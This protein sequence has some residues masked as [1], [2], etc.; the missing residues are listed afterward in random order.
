[1]A[2]TDS[3]YMNIALALAER[4]LGRVW[5]NPAVG[6]VLVQPDSDGG[7]GRIVG[8]GWTQPGGRPHAE[9][10]ALAQAGG[11]AKGASAYVSLEPCSHHGKAPPCADAL[12]AAGVSRV[13]MAVEDPDP[14]VCGQGLAKLRAARIEV[15]T[16]LLAREARALNRG[17]FT[18]TALGRPMFTL[19]TATT[20][21]GRIATKSR[22]SKWIT[23]EAARAKGHLLRAQHDAVLT[24]YGTVIADDPLLNC[25]IP[26]LEDRSPIRIVVDGGLQTPLTA[27]VIKTARDI[28]TWII[29]RKGA[30][31]DRRK[32]L[33]KLG[34]DILE[35]DAGADGRPNMTEGARALGE[36][37]LTRVLVEAG[38]ILAASLV[39]SGLA[40]AIAWFRAA[41]L[42]G[43]DGL[44][45]IGDL[46]L[47]GI[48]AAIA[49]EHVS[50]L[51]LG[52]DV[53]ETYV[54]PA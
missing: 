50:S 29:A 40:D 35:V 13:V 48:D 37:G 12:I 14:R 28:P 27:Q 49:F 10:E 24:G 9:T 1:M 31:P 46:G 16:G 39:K 42:V 5:P 25:R 52:G 3:W 36:R 38:G 6:C 22:D 26:G 41:K 11:P 44:P 47:P 2:N 32:T 30:D 7:P 15:S 18:R 8:R 53:L 4:G 33:E 43:G 17:F 23:G 19:K 54:R 21:D 45:A 34:V 20:L 51:A